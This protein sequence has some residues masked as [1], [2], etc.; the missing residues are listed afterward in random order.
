MRVFQLPS[1]FSQRRKP[2][3]VDTPLLTRDELQILL[4]RAVA[5][6]KNEDFSHSEQRHSGLAASRFLGRGMDFEESRQYQ[7]GDEI[8]HI[9]WR[10]SAR[11]PQWQ[12]KVY[13][14]E[15]QAE[16]IVVVD[17]SPTLRF[18]T[19]GQLKITQAV[20]AA[21]VA[22]ALAQAQHASV[23][24]LSTDTLPHSTSGAA[25]E[26][27]LLA[28]LQAI[29]SPAPPQP[30]DREAD[31]FMQM[32]STL[33]QQESRGDHLFLISDF[34][35]MGKQHR[36]LLAQ[37]CNASHVHAVHIIDPAE[38]ELPSQAP[39]IF[40]DEPQQRPIA[41]STRSRKVQQTYA[42]QANALLESRQQALQA[43]GTHYLRLMTTD[44][45]LKVMIS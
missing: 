34:S 44:D 23:K 8:R 42:H 17:R 28:L 22:A 7:P 30:F 1:K 2:R 43:S 19:R 31:S 6:L 10:L 38:T 18:G 3:T 25:S 5:R 11:S 9:N 14:E 29:A 40:L 32:L 41:I 35:S 12:S 45:A 15:R 27:R 39:G 36:P 33:T 4:A 24:I 13:A 21:V 20:Q 16:I 26:S 37:L